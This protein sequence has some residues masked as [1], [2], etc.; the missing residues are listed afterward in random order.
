MKKQNNQKK[1]KKNKVCPVCGKEYE[2]ALSI[3]YLPN[4]TQQ[5]KHDNP[6]IGLSKIEKKRRA[7]IEASKEAK[8]LAAEYAINHPPEET[9]RVEPKYFDDGKKREP[10]DVP[11]KVVEKIK[12]TIN[13]VGVENLT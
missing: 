11:K 10:L 2:Y 3:T 9:V 4:G 7:N 13:E 6:D 8:R 1:E 12:E 5:C